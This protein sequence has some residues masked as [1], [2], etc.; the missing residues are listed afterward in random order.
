MDFIDFLTPEFNTNPYS[1]YKLM[2]DFYPLYFHPQ[3]RSL[4]FEQV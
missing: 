4:C 1:Y 3:N 2:R